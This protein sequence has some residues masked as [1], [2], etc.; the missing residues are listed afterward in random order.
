MN[1]YRAYPIPTGTQQGG[2]GVAYA[3]SGYAQSEAPPRPRL[4]ILCERL[5][6][7]PKVAGTA[8]DRA[9]RMADRL[10]G[11]VPTPVEKGDAIPTGGS[12]AAS[13]ENSIQ[14]LDNLLGKI[15]SELDRLERF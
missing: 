7:L 13:L 15:H 1:D 5:D 10:G 9:R 12:V 2:T 6:A 11:S 8:L 14:L 3:T 4:D